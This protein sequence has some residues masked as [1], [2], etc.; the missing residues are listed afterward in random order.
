MSRSALV[1]CLDL[2]PNALAHGY[3]MTE[4]SGMVAVLG[5]EERHGDG[6]RLWPAGRPIAGVELEVCDPNT[7]ARLPAG[8]TGEVW[9]RSDHLMAGYWHDPEVTRAVLPG[10]GWYRTGDGGRLDADGY[11]YLTDRLQ[12][13][14]ISGGTDVYPAEVERVLAELPGV[15][16]V[17]VIGVPD[18]C[19]GEVPKAVVVAAAGH[20]VDEAE[21]LAHCK[22]HLT[23]EQCPRSV[24]VVAHLPRNVAGKV[25]KKDLY[26][27][28]WRR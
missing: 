15:A 1:R 16:D 20:T 4:A 18:E 11:L 27:R 8:R 9:I 24:D 3:G 14:I 28:Y 12:D 6:H 19:W 13:R 2:F 22:R 10:D 7:G 17:A 5:P 26:P 25:T 21:L 23:P